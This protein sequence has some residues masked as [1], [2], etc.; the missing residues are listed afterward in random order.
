MSR[1]SNEQSA[2]VLTIGADT[3]SLV[4]VPPLSPRETFAHEMGLT[5]A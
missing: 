2:V 4:N 1:D 5:Q 3:A